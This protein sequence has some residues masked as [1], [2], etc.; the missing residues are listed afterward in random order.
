M[1]QTMALLKRLYLSPL[2]YV[3][4]A[5]LNLLSVAHRPFMVY[6]FYNQATRKFHLMT[7]ISSTVAIM[8]R[9]RLDLGD[10]VWVWHHS[11]LDASNG[12]KIGR[13]SQIGAWVGIFTHSS[14]IAIRLLGDRYLRLDPSQRTGYQRGSVEIGEYTFI[15][16]SSLVLPGVTIGRGCVV[17]AGSVVTRSV[18]D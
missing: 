11:I 13:G 2:G 6:G 10:N 7:R 14:H 8:G 18:P 4:S 16:A 9:R 17:A 1:L 12:L 15:G 3:V 5:A